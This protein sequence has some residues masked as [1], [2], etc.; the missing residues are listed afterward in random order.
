MDFKKYSS[1]E[2]IYRI[3]TI[4]DIKDYGLHYGDW[5]V[6]EKVHGANLSFWMNKEGLRVAKRT[7]F[8]MNSD[9]FFNWQSVTDEYLVH[10]N[11]LLEV[12]GEVFN[13]SEDTLEVIL[14][15]ELFGGTYPHPNVDKTLNAS[16]VQSG[17][18]YCPDNDFYAFDLKVNGQ[19]INYCIFEEI[20]KNLGFNYARPL[21]IGNFD[22]C[23]AYP[24]SFQ[25]TI[26]DFYSLPDIEDNICEGVV[27]KPVDAKFFDN[28]S[29][30][31]LKNKN[32]R[33]KEK[34][35]KPKKVVKEVV[36][37][38]EQEKSI[39]ALNEYVTEN[40]LKNVISKI[41]EVTD[42]DFGK[43]LGA[44][45]KDI[46]EE[47]IKDDESFNNMEKEDRKVVTKLLSKDVALFLRQRFLNVIDNTL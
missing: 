26:P 42:K 31:I 11:A 19:F 1:I 43:I 44:F 40:R 10:L 14:Y 15:G 30:V 6:T 38:E 4:S 5:V 39:S 20:M 2:N 13:I 47:H 3:K 35:K 22:E 7:S 9:S 34:E 37:S 28:G 8:L 24:N 25:T 32:D 46:L 36:L 27:I 16:K 12:C 23:L 33:F 29:R 41:G 17:V 45:T 21:K 18:Y